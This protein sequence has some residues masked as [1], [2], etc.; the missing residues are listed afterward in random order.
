M[1]DPVLG[2]RGRAEEVQLVLENG[3]V[4]PVIGTSQPQ[5]DGEQALQARVRIAR[6][7][8]ASGSPRKATEGGIAEPLDLRSRTI[9]SLRLP[10]QARQVLDT[11]LAGHGKV[12]ESGVVATVR[13]GKDGCGS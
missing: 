1:K 5:G 2:L 3:Q 9:L 10:V 6:H 4:R 7:W 8:G 12:P 11:G 13:V